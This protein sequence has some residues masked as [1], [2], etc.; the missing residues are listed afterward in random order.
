MTTN[1]LPLALEVRTT[2]WPATQESEDASVHP[3]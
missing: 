3:P 2:D 1:H